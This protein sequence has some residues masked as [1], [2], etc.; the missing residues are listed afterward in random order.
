MRKIG[1]PQQKPKSQF[2]L[3][4]HLLPSPLQK[5]KKKVFCILSAYRG[6]RSTATKQCS[7]AQAPWASF[8][9]LRF[10]VRKTQMMMMMYS[11]SWA[12]VR[13]Q[14]DYPGSGFWVGVLGSWHRVHTRDLFA[15]NSPIPRYHRSLGLHSFIKPS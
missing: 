8:L 12:A 3:I 4:L 14:S 6:D 1:K 9:R 11:S 13:T 7:R 10:L 5:K 2:Q 15:V